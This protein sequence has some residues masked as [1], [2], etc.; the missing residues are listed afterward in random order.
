MKTENNFLK[1]FRENE[2]EKLFEILKIKQLF[3]DETDEDVSY[4]IFEISELIEKIYLIHI[5]KIINN[6]DLSKEK[7]E[8]IFDDIK[9]DF[10]EIRQLIETSKLKGLKYWDDED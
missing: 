1:N 2:S 10:N 9:F 3:N 6:S 7:L 8:E 5:P 4:A